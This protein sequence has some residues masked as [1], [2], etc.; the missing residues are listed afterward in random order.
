MNYKLFKLKCDNSVSNFAF[1]FYLAPLHQGCVFLL[2]RFAETLRNAVHGGAAG[3]AAGVGGG[4]A[5]ADAGEGVTLS[6]QLA[7]LS[8][9]ELR[10]RLA[11]LGHPVDPAEEAAARADGGNGARRLF[12]LR[13]LCAAHG[14]RESSSGGVAGGG[15]E[16]G[17]HG[18]VGGGGSAGGG[19]GGGG[20]GAEGGGGAGGEA[21]GVGG[22]ATG[23]AAGALAEEAAAGRVESV[24]P[25]V[26]RVW[27]R[28]GAGAARPLPPEAVARALAALRAL[29]WPRK[30]DRAVAASHYLSLSNLPTA[31]A[32]QRQRMKRYRWLWDEAGALLGGAAGPGAAA[33]FDGLAVTH[34]MV[35]SPHTDALDVAPQ[36]AVCLGD[37]A[38][39]G[40]GRCRLTLSNSR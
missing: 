13:A 21:E 22:G 37:F 8:S 11:S 28:C 20:V 30:R 34:N 5:D 12:L 24:P 4:A 7:P 9:N 31:N 26:P 39:P 32:R 33:A 6:A 3:G 25:C 14:E 18:A 16:R 29:Q 35:G 10:G 23:G 17:V 1:K 40:V 27:R 15:C 38:G 2:R 19:H 36:F